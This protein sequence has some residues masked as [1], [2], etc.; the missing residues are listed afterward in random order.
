MAGNS[1]KSEALNL[2]SAGLSLGANTLALTKAVSD[3]V[4]TGSSLVDICR[5]MMKWLARERIDEAEFE[6]C[7]IQTRGLT[8][9]N[10]R[11]MKIREK[12]AYTNPQIKKLGGLNLT[13][14]GSLG[15]MM[16]FDTELTYMVTT[17]AAV[18]AY[19]D[20]KFAVDALCYMVQDTKERHE[21]GAHK[22]GINYPYSVHR[23]RLRP[24]VGKITESIALNVVNSG[25]H[26]RDIPEE[27][28]KFCIHTV[29]PSTFSAVVMATVRQSESDVLLYSGRFYGDVFLWLQ[30]HYSGILEVYI[31]GTR[32]YQEVLGHSK[33]RIKMLIRDFCKP[34]QGLH[35][36]STELLMSVDVSGTSVP[37]LTRSEGLATGLS[38]ANPSK[39]QGLYDIKKANGLYAHS[40]LSPSELND[41]CAT[42]QAIAKWLLELSVKPINDTLFG[43]QAE[44]ETTV[45]GATNIGH[46]LKHWPVIGQ[47]KFGAGC[48]ALSIFRGLSQEDKEKFDEKS[49]TL[50]EITEYFPIIT[51]LL[52]SIKSRCDCTNC[53]SLGPIGKGKLGCLREK[54]LTLV[55][56]LLAH[57]IANG[58][59]APDA[60]GVVDVDLLKSSVQHLLAELITKDTVLWDSWFA[61]AAIVYMGCPLDIPNLEIIE[62]ATSIVAVQYGSLA[63]VGRW[64]DIAAELTVSGCFGFDIGEGRLCGVSDEFA[65]VQAERRMAASLAAAE[66]LQRPEATFDNSDM[67][68]SVVKV[69]TAIIGAAGI[70]YRLLTMVQSNLH[71]RIVDP[72]DAIMSLCRSDIP[73]CDH[74]ASEA[75]N[76]TEIAP[77]VLELW[78]LD[79]AIGYWNTENDHVELGLH[80]IWTTAVCD[81]HLKLNVALSLSF[82]GCIIRGPRLCLECAIQLAMASGRLASARRILR[83]DVKSRSL[84]KSST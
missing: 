82:H 8:I 30:V 54:A 60:S 5:D 10:E 65:V 2:A 49:P 14:A 17:V 9:P 35:G 81:S 23:A 20:Q 27:L 79:K 80:P 7:T 55:F 62:G 50:H 63:V 43:F 24:V 68:N 11:G 58:F 73:Q 70:P 41:I 71:L 12:L 29:N 21:A 32:L 37:I 3:T 52:E 38:G 72:S 46:L 47:M 1:N 51:T 78:D 40:V 18:M 76:R 69:E 84:I 13:L 39:R 59:G 53:L 74:K 22:K 42:A 64:V 36:S 4:I 19:H 6:Y 56:T 26:F 77:G 16:A 15:R 28:E 48:K 61:V 25:H 75:S 83:V 44:L 34:E 31:G 45:V 33:G 57:T 66:I 67:E